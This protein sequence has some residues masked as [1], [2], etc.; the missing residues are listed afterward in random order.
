MKNKNDTGMVIHRVVKEKENNG[1]EIIQNHMRWG[2]EESPMSENRGGSG[3]G[4]WGLGA[5]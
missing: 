3:R 5:S 2:E 1:C 4:G